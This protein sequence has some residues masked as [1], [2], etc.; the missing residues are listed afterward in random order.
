[1]WQF[2]PPTRKP[3]EENRSDT[4]WRWLVTVRRQNSN[5]KRSGFTMKTTKSNNNNKKQA[6]VVIIQAQCVGTH[7]TQQEEVATTIWGFGTAISCLMTGILVGVV[8][9]IAGQ[10][11][12]SST[13]FLNVSPTVAW[14]CV[15]SAGAKA[16]CH[17]SILPSQNTVR[18]VSRIEPGASI[19]EIP[20]GFQLST[21]DAFRD[22]Q[23]QHELLGARLRL[24]DFPLDGGAFLAAYLVLQQEK[25][26]QL[27]ISISITESE[28]SGSCA[29]ATAATTLAHFF[30]SLPPMVQELASHPVFL[31]EPARDNLHL[32][33][34][35]EGLIALHRELLELEYHALYAA[36]KSSSSSTSSF[37]VLVKEQDYIMMRLVVRTRGVIQRFIPEE[38]A[39]PNLCDQSLDEELEF[40]R[41]KSGV[42]L[43]DNIMVLVLGTMDHLNHHVADGANA[44]CSFHPNS[45]LF[46][47][48]AASTIQAGEQIRISFTNSTESRFFS[49]YGYLHADSAT[50]TMASIAVFHKVLSMDLSISQEANNTARWLKRQR[51]NKEFLSSLIPYLQYDDGYETCVDPNTSPQE[52]VELKRLKWEHLV[53]VA[54]LQKRWLFALDPR[55]PRISSVSSVGEADASGATTAAD[56]TAAATSKVRPTYS[57]NTHRAATAVHPPEFDPELRITMPQLVDT[58]RIMVLTN[59]DY[60]GNV[61][62]FIREAL[63]YYKDDVF[64]PPVTSPDLEYR[65]LHCV[66]RLA[67]LALESYPASSITQEKANWIKLN[68]QEFQSRDWN[69]SH[70]RLGEMQVSNH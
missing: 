8:A 21:L 49:H 64:P 35:A 54:N 43:R 44:V 10:T 12:W 39:L 62:G 46:V 4:K 60:N 42:N 14:M 1:L 36:S 70:L 29:T 55:Q 53:R 32:A 9:V 28:S 16:V 61:V 27:G 40:Y 68:Q 33:S 24:Q 30:S 58:C 51:A 6:A 59:S 15:S 20:R 65:T 45:G 38:D 56:T 34:P 50:S 69:W 26:R 57:V 19:F 66:K 5:N 25:E 13:G 22:P 23:I 63:E 31:W 52:Q 48:K 47:V 41:Q 2:F 18:A 3:K 17:A 7:R 11:L 37:H 67:G